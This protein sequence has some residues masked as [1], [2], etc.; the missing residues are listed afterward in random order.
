[1]DAPLPINYGAFGSWAAC[2]LV[3]AFNK[4]GQL[5]FLTVKSCF[6]QRFF[7]NSSGSETDDRSAKRKWWTSKAGSSY[8][9][10]VR[11]FD[12]LYD[13]II[14]YNNRSLEEV[15]ATAEGLRLS[16]EAFSD[17][18][19]KSRDVRIPKHVKNL[20]LEQ[21]FFVAFAQVYCSNDKR[22][23]KV[24]NTLM[25]KYLPFLDAFK[26]KKSIKL[27]KCRL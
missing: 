14:G 19:V 5:F 16:F 20:S 17:L 24:V 23:Q 1:M 22:E 3:F 13:P 11:C 21:I 2:D 9:E 25:E 26:C 12:E 6:L 18:V 15:I 10:S 27:K 8:S 4:N 7:F